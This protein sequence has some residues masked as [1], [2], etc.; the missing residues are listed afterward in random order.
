MKRDKTNIVFLKMSLK[1]RCK[2]IT[3]ESYTRVLIFKY[4]PQNLITD[5]TNNQCGNES[6]N[7]TLE[8]VAFGSFQYNS[9][10]D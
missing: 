2:L 3:F 4:F 8:A 10:I 7:I 9:N 5:Y 1:H 6:V